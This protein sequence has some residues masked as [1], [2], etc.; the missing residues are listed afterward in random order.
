M[1]E[2]EYRTILFKAKAINQ[3]FLNGPIFTTRD[4]TLPGN[5]SSGFEIPIEKPEYLKDFEWVE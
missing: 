5:V 2:G 3:S 4:L 1:P